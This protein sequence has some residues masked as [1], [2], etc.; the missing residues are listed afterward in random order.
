MPIKDRL[1][2]MSRHALRALAADWFLRGF[3]LSGRG[4]HG[5]S[6]PSDHEGARSILLA[7]FDRIWNYRR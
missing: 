2:H 3:A 4:F 1:V 7:E 6:L 5:E